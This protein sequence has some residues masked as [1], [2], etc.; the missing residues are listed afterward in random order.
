MSS[1]RARA[2][3]VAREVDLTKL[4]VEQ[5]KEKVKL[6]ANIATQKVDPDAQLAI[7]EAEQEAVRKETTRMDTSWTGSRRTERVS[8]RQPCIQ[9]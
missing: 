7:K 8:G 2:R 4:R 6:G 1:S 9:G 5:V 3:A